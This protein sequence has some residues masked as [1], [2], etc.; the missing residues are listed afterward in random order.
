[1]KAS[2]HHYGVIFYHVKKGVGEFSQH[3]FPRLFVRHRIRALVSTQIF[4]RRSG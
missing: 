1:M 4:Q 3:S 2:Q